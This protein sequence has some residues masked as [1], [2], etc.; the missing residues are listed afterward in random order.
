MK[1]KFENF[2]FRQAS[3]DTIDLCNT[4][5]LE[6]AAQGFALTLR[7]LYYQMVARNFIPNRQTEYKRLGTIVGKARLAGLIDWGAIE[8]RT[9]FLR[10]NTWEQTPEDA[11]R[12]LLDKYQIEKWMGQPFRPEV[13][14]EKDALIGVIQE[15]C[16][17]LDIDYFSCRGYVSL[18]EMYQA[19]YL[20]FRRYLKEGQTPVIIHLGDHDPSGMDMTRDIIA[21]TG[22]LSGGKI[23]VRR[24]ALNMPQV[25]EYQPP[26]NF[27]KLSDSRA[28][29]YVRK[30]GNESWELDA[31]SPTVLAALIETE[32]LKLRDE[33]LWDAKAE[34]ES[35][36]RAR[37]YDFVENI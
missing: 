9:R 35:D 12:A 1:I 15:V 31:L 34:E 26:P 14:I 6:Y 20:R 18:S 8:D 23:E 19:G 36:G 22:M 3:L 21:R 28:G 4:I 16:E 11:V 25:D 2:N 33:D 10:G 7:Q 13:W 29:E 17:R 5:I 32:V 37:L 24:I 27:A 30:Y